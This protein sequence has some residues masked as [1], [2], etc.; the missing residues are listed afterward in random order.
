VWTLKL[1][2]IYWKCKAAMHIL[3][4]L[5]MSKSELLFKK[6]YPYTR[7]YTS[8]LSPRL[9]IL[10]HTTGSEKVASNGDAGHGRSKFQKR[11]FCFAFFFRVRYLVYLYMY[12]Q[13][14]KMISRVAYGDGLLYLYQSRQAK[15][16]HCSNLYVRIQA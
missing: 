8:S 4:A 15:T 10:F 16:V 9:Y 11:G 6:N 2:P 1:L 12:E 5:A 7:V 13:Y 3:V 14:L